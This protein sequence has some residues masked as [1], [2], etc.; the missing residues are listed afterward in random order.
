[1][2]LDAAICLQEKYLILPFKPKLKPLLL[3]KYLNSGLA[4]KIQDFE[5]FSFQRLNPHDKVQ[6]HIM[7]S[8]VGPEKAL[9][10]SLSYF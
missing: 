5:G 1:M 8:V 7:D 2:F 4:L 9:T 10:Y 3:S 6:P